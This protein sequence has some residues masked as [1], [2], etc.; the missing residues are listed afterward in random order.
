MVKDR[1]IT[2]Y[3]DLVQKIL[4]DFQFIELGLKLYI[5]ETYLIIATK[6]KGVVPF[7]YGWKDVENEPLGKLLDRFVKINADHDLVKKLRPLQKE[8]NKL[9]HQ[10]YIITF[11][12]Q[13]D[14]EYIKNEYTRLSDL[15]TRTKPLVMRTLQ[16]YGEVQEVKRK[17]IEQR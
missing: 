12:E 11:E 7:K 17:I 9:V 6:V 14:K 3:L 5:A 10:A 16:V 13:S 8:R 1:S 4:L 2:E 15:K